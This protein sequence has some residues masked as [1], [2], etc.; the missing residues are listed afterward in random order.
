MNKKEIFYKVAKHLMKQGR[1]S[2]KGTECVYLASDGAKCAVGC[3]IPRKLYTPAIEGCGI[4]HDGVVLILEKLGIKKY[5]KFLGELQRLHDDEM[6]QDWPMRLTEIAK[7]HHWK[8][9]DCVRA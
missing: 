2:K 7:E 5:Q 9:P 1:R 3:L 8:I 6:V 4:L